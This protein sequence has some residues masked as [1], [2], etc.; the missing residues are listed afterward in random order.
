MLFSVNNDPA[1]GRWI[2]DRHQ[3]ES[4]IEQG[5]RMRGCRQA[6]AVFTN[7]DADQST[8]ASSFCIFESRRTLPRPLDLDADLSFDL[9]FSSCPSMASP[10]KHPPLVS[11]PFFSPL[12]HPKCRSL[13][14]PLPPSPHPVS[15]QTSMPAILPWRAS[16]A[17]S[18]SSRVCL[19]NL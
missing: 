16:E 11:S 14:S 15:L 1:W 4:S 6:R 8:S 2:V 19:K 17:R 13:A 5:R 9:F 3:T 18:S 7:Y 12:T 10:I